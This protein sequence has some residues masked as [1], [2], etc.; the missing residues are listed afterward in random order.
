MLTNVDPAIFTTSNAVELQPVVSAEWNQNLF[1]PPYLTTAG[2]GIS[3]TVTYS[4]GGTVT[5]I[6]PDT[7][8][9]GFSTYSFKVSNGSAYVDYYVTT[10]NSS[11]AYKIVFWVKTDNP[12]PLI[13]SAYGTG[14]STQYGSSSTEA[15]SFG[16]T[17]VTTIVGSSGSSDGINSFNFVINASNLDSDTT[18][19]L[20]LIHI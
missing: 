8:L 13:I 7:T 11:P 5:P 14:T 12:I 16:W 10:A 6:G 2:L 3:E 18:Q 17:K 15:N 19:T 9:P 20:S 1:N 4:S